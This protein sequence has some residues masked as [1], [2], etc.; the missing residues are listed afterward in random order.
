MAYNV[1]IVDD[2]A[3][4]RMLIR[5]V[6]TIS[7]FAIHSFFE[8]SNGRDALN[9]LEANRADVILCDLYMPEMDG[10][11]FL[12]TLRTHKLWRT[13]PVV[14]ITSESRQEVV[15]PLLEGG[16]QGYIKKPFHLETLRDQLMDI[17]G[18]VA[19]PNVR[20]FE[21]CDF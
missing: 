19:G 21:G 11:A 10:A 4:M 12:Q 20:E 13:I 8:G 6:L 2:S 9:I 14:L 5:K 3:T 16:V 17:L 1:L 7:G 15:G 18:E